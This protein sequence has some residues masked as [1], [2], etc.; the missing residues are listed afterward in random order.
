LKRDVATLE[1]D[2]TP[3]FFKATDMSDGMMLPNTLAWIEERTRALASQGDSS[4]IQKQIRE[5]G[6]KRPIP[7][8][9]EN[10]NMSMDREGKIKSTLN[11]I[12]ELER[13]CEE[14]GKI[15]DTLH[16]DDV[17]Q[18]QEMM[19]QLQLLKDRTEGDTFKEITHEDATRAQLRKLKLDRE[20]RLMIGE[21]NQLM[22]K[23]G[24]MQKEKLSTTV[25]QGTLAEIV[26][27]FPIEVN[28]IGTVASFK[29]PAGVL[30]FPWD[31]NRQDEL[32]ASKGV[33]EPY[34]PAPNDAERWKRIISDAL[35][36]AQP[37][38]CILLSVVK[39]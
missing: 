17:L 15:I 6:K 14:Y 7:P 12:E 33:F 37:V 34:S 29:F 1:A 39:W 2:E 4:T 10:T 32:D 21:L 13:Q 23:V 22:E 18:S 11:E 19:K 31:P 24:D 3:S 26:S 5:A 8:M 38:S 28:E 16:V 20:V 25:L 36:R 35:G 9:P 30:Y 27:H